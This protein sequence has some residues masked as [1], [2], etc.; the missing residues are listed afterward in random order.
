M[1]MEF[2]VAVC[3]LGGLYSSRVVGRCAVEEQV[4]RHS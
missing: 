1:N 3:L 2:L 4:E